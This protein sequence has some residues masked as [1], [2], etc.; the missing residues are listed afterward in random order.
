MCSLIQSVGLESA[1]TIFRK[2]FLDCFNMNMMGRS[3]QTS[4]LFH[5]YLIFL[6]AAEIKRNGDHFNP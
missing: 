5:Q 3:K 4:P 2:K 6:I 1:K